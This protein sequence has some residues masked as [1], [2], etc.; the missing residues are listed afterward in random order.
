MA[1][2]LMLLV[3]VLF[4]SDSAL[5]VLQLSGNFCLE[6]FLLFNTYVRMYI[7]TD[8]F[9]LTFDWDYKCVQEKMTGRLFYRYGKLEIKK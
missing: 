7:C 4:N 9:G 2:K 6:N 1:E 5:C 3:P 8:C